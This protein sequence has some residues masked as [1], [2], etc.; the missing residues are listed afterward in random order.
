MVRNPLTDGNDSDAE[1]FMWEGRADKE[2]VVECESGTILMQA[3]NLPY[4]ADFDT[5]SGNFIWTPEKEGEY[6][7]TFTADD[8]VIPISMQVNIIV[9]D[10]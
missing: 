5:L 9:E 10:E 1:Q 6:H 2:Y 4:G 3:E 7:I 8:G